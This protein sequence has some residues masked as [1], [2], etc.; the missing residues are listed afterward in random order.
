MVTISLNGFSP[1]RLTCVVSL[2]LL[3]AN[4]PPVTGYFSGG[5][6]VAEQDSDV[7]SLAAIAAY[8]AP[9]SPAQQ[10]AN[11]WEAIKAS[12]DQRKSGGVL[13]NGKWFHTDTDSRIQQLGLVMMGAA[14]PA[15]SWKTMDGTFTTMS[16][17]LAG[18]IFQAVAGLDMAL[19]SAAETHRAEMEASAHP[20][21]YD[22]ST[23]WPAH[24]T[25]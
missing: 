8:F 4:L 15:V 25:V 19:F 16:Q 5:E 1:D 7:Q 14:V 2:M 17:S 6:F 9:E 10:K 12:R 11:K 18:Q 23:G 24:F 3:E 22:F 13:V 20:D 21:Q